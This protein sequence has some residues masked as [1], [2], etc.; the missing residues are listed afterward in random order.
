M[1]REWWKKKLHISSHRHRSSE[2]HHLDSQTL[3]VPASLPI[4]AATPPD[5]FDTQDTSLSEDLWKSAYDELKPEEQV[6]LSTVQVSAESESEESFSQA[7]HIVDGVIQITE[8]QYKEYQQGGIKIHRS[9]GEVIDIRGVSQKILDAA[10]LFKDVITAVVAF[11]PT[12]H[13]ASAW[14]VVSLGLT[15]SHVT[16]I[17]EQQTDILNHRWRRI[18]LTY[19]MPC[20]NRPNTLQTLLLNAP[21]LK[22]SFTA[23]ASRKRLR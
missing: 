15:V 14:A 21:I 1:M 3:V 20:L 6:I 4:T 8:N 18:D 9:T 5:T 17:T 22:R 23:I 13:A 2:P 7:G 10:L 16:I 12:H 11:D 19:E